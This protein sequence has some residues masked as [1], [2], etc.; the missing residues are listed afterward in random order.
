M[1]SVNSGVSFTGTVALQQ[2]ADLARSR[3]VKIAIVFHSLKS[4]NP[5]IFVSHYF[6]ALKHTVIYT[7]L[8]IGFVSQKPS[9]SQFHQA[10]IKGKQL[11]KP[12]S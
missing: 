7:Y 5:I 12:A 8:L 2:L 6:L 9:P 3:N 11:A 10:L 4:Q 1:P